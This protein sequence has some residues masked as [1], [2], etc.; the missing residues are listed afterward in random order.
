M[1]REYSRLKRIV[2]SL[3]ILIGSFAT[4]IS[5]GL[6]VQLATG[7]GLSVTSDIDSSVRAT[8]ALLV[9]GVVLFVDGLR[10]GRRWW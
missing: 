6:F 9:V 4:A 7:S 8:I 1:A 3:E 10:R 2:V 5:F